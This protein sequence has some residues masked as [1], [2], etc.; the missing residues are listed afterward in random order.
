MAKKV[1]AY[2]DIGYRIADL[3][4][5]Q[6]QIAKVLRVS[7]QTVSKKL[8]GETAILLSDLQKLAAHYKVPLTY[9]FE[10]EGAPAELAAA[11]ERVRSGPVVLKEITVMLSRLPE[12]A[13]QRVHELTKFIVQG[14]KGSKRG[15]KGSRSS[16]RDLLAAEDP[17]RYRK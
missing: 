7:Q 10:E 1:R 14:S 11:W 2:T 4:K 13:I 12:S 16:R 17:G 9:F 3:G 15:R 8:R 6:R 5:R